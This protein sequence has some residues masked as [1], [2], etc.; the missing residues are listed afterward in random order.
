MELNGRYIPYL[1]MSQL[2]VITL[3]MFK[4]TLGNAM[5]SLKSAG[6]HVEEFCV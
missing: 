3:I 5:D 2:V 4:Y 1:E 6:K